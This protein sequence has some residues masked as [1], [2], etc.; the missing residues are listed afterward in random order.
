MKN[1]VSITKNLDIKRSVETLIISLTK[2]GSAGQKLLAMVLVTGLVGGYAVSTLSCNSSNEEYL[3][4]ISKLN[5]TIKSLESEKN[6]LLN[7]NS[8]LQKNIRE[9]EEDL[10]D[11]EDDLSACQE[12]SE[13]A[14]GEIVG[15]RGE[16]RDTESNLTILQKTIREGHGGVYIGLYI[17]KVEV[18]VESDQVRVTVGNALE[19]NTVIASI[20]VMKGNLMYFDRSENATGILEGEPEVGNS[21]VFVWDEQEASAPEGFIDVDDCYTIRVTSIT[22]QSSIALYITVKMGISV[23]EWKINQD[24]IHVGVLNEVYRFPFPQT[25]KLC[26]KKLGFDDVF[27]NVSYPVVVEEGTLGGN[28]YLWNES[29]SGAP[30]GFLSKDSRY[31]IRVVYSPE[32]S[33]YH[34]CKQYSEEIVRAPRTKDTSNGE[35]E[36]PEEP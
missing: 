25:A 34:W 14:L 20:G 21:E 11:T 16:L 13:R 1:N 36:P 28:T 22:G 33:G 19:I 15:I 3:T 9:L 35:S 30:S 4:R 32:E 7:N 2:M 10:G 12:T 31:L 17:V 6:E 24:Y 29:V 27:Y 18:D 5:D 8:G 23:D 26:V